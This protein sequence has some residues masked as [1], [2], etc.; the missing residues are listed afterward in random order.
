[1]GRS[2]PATLPG[3]APRPER[4][5]APCERGW[6]EAAAPPSWRVLLHPPRLDAVRRD[7]PALPQIPPPVAGPRARPGRGPGVA[8]PDLRGLL[9]PR[10]A[11]AGD[12]LS[13]SRA[14]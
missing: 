10:S 6:S 8:V 9:R 14:S 5:S 13:P 7:D 12:G 11:R 3:A 2:P 4:P 1:D